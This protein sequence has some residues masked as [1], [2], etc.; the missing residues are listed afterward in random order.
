MKRF[1]DNNGC[2]VTLTFSKPLTTD[3]KHVLVICRYDG[4]WLLTN[5]KERGLEF[6]GGKVEA[7]EPL[8]EAAKRELYE[9]TGAIVD[10]LTYIG[11]YEVDCKGVSFYKN[12]YFGH[13]KRFEE[14]P[15]YFETNGPVFLQQFP[16]NIH[17]D[18]NFSYIMKDDLLPNVLAELKRRRLI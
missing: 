14:R 4:K 9:E 17:L 13:V 1:F 16:K 5:H 2:H 7:G 3:V 6:P 15:H 18:P 10:S 12:I 11:Q 8:M